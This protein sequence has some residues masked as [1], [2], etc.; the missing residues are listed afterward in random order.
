MEL[1]QKYNVSVLVQKQG[2]I[3]KIE[4]YKPFLFRNIL[5]LIQFIWIILYKNNKIK[6]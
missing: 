2:K 4:K 5:L 1:L 3:T 6:L